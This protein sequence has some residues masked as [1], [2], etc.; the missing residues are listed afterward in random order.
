MPVLLR[1]GEFL[2]RLVEISKSVEFAPRL[3]LIGSDS[4]LVITQ[5]VQSQFETREQRIVDKARA[6][7]QELK[8]KTDSSC[9]SPNLKKSFLRLR[10]QLRLLRKQVQFFQNEFGLDL[11]THVNR[12]AS[13]V[14]RV[15]HRLNICDT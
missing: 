3:E 6:L 2:S 8:S 13:A 15:R 14:T 5:L 9:G 11:T 4:N 10:S 12:V 1:P 7:Y